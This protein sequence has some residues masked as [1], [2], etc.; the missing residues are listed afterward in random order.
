MSPVIKYRN[1]STH[2]SDI[3]SVDSRGKEFPIIG[4]SIEIQNIPKNVK[5]KGKLMKNTRKYKNKLESIT[6]SVTKSI[7]S[8]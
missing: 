7:N 8:R 5:A 1:Y 6:G 4:N 2:I 3:S